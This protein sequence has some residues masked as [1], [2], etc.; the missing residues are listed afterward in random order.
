MSRLN[1]CVGVV[2]LDELLVVV[3]DVLVRGK[4]LSG[5]LSPVLLHCDQVLNALRGFLDLDVA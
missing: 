2:G 3:K 4:E 5:W 1:V